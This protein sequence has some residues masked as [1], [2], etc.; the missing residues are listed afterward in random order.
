LE[1]RLD[2]QISVTV[3]FFA[4]LIVPRPPATP[5]QPFDLVFKPLAFFLFSVML[6]T[7]KRTLKLDARFS[8]SFT[9][10]GTFNP[11]PLKFDGG[12][13]LLS[14][15][16]ALKPDS[17]GLGFAAFYFASAQGRFCAT[18]D[19][20]PSGFALDFSGTEEVPSLP[21][22]PQLQVCVDVKPSARYRIVRIDPE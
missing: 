18:F 4:G 2:I 19:Y 15:A 5:G 12:L 17:L 9:I 11:L 6:D 7:T 16:S 22:A 10:R 14:D 20:R 3:A 1:F 8:L 13:K 21:L